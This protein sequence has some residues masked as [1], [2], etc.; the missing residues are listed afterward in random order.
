MTAHALSANRSTRTGR[1]ILPPVVSD[2]PPPSAW[3][4]RRLRRGGCH[5]PS[6]QTYLVAFAD[7]DREPTLY[8][9][10]SNHLQYV[11]EVSIVGDLDLLL[12][13]PVDTLVSRLREAG[14][15]DGTIGLVGTDPRYETGMPY[16]HRDGLRARLDADLT[17]ATPRFT[18]LTAVKSDAEV[19]RIARAATALD[20]AMRALGAAAEP[21]A[22]ERDL[23]SVVAATLADEG[24]DVGTT[25][26]STAPMTDAQSGEP[27][28]W[29]R[30]PADRTVDTGD[31]V[32]TEISA[33]S[34]GYASQIH[35]PYAVDASPTDQ[36]R[37]LFAVARAVYDEMLDAIRPGNTVADVHAAMAAVEDSPYKTYD[38]MLHGYGN[39]YQHPFVGTAA[40]TYWPGAD[41][42]ATADW[43]FEENQVLV[44]QPNVVTDDE[45]AGLQLGTTVVVRDDGADV[46][47]DYPVAFIEP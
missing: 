25:F 32:T 22:S 17:D 9:G 39:G 13:D 44:V 1:G 35:R 23:R 3:K 19:E 28:P 21:G 14:V 30:T 15:D 16:N 37:E 41:D 47:Q 43:V 24:C 38:V 20:A 27:L 29:K 42:P 10:L 2:R 45:T 36:Y 34:Q 6:Y 8:V 18:S 11:R 12:P 7:P 26:L 31:V 40:S 46:L 33:V 5:E 4:P